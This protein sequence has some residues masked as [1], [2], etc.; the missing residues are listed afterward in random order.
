MSNVKL[1]EIEVKDPNGQGVKPGQKGKKPRRRKNDPL[2]ENLGTRRVP[3]L[4]MAD[5]PDADDIVRQGLLTGKALGK[6]C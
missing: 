6:S 1:D 2:R 3:R 5:F 4:R